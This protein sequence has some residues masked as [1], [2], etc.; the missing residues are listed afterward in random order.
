VRIID[1]DEPAK[2]MSK[3]FGSRARAQAHEFDFDTHPSELAFRRKQ[4]R[5]AGYPGS[6]GHVVHQ[7]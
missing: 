6:G 7:R 3:G 1:F 2:I 5:R 4:G